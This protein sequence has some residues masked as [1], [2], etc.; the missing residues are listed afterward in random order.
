[1][2]AMLID[3]YF[4][5]SISQGASIEAKVLYLKKASALPSLTAI[6]QLKQACINAKCM[7]RKCIRKVESKCQNSF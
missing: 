1:M 7:S 3:T 2:N 6:T 4:D 5:T